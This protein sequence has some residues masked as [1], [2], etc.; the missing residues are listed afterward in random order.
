MKNIKIILSYDGSDFLG[1][2]KTPLGPTIEESLEKVFSQILQE[3]IHL[4]AASRTDAGVHAEGQTVNF[5]TSKEPLCLKKLHHSANALLPKSMVILDIQEECLSFHPT[6]DNIGKEY[7]YLVCNEPWQKPKNRFYSWHIPLPLD[8]DAM[9]TAAASLL[10]THDFSSFCNERSLLD[11]NP[12]CTL[13]S[14][15][16]NSF[17]KGRLCFKISGDRFLFRMVRNLVGTLAY[18]GLGKINSDA[19]SKVLQGRQR[20]LAGVTAPAHGLHLM[21]VFYNRSETTS[22]TRTHYVKSK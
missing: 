6:L 20:A 2:Q 10:G 9:L 4:Q 22:T 5:L 15:E 14:I 21:Q 11:K 1:W 13:Q 16:I 3:P 8:Q 19:I 12:V 18:V 7:H 17:E